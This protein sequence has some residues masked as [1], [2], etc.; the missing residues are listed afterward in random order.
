MTNNDTIRSV[1]FALD[2]S[3]AEIGDLFFLGGSPI[4]DEQLMQYLRKEEDKGFEECPSEL[5]H[6]F[7]DGLI[8]NKRGA[9]DGPALRYDASRISNN[10]ILRKLRIAF[11]LKDTDVVDI[12][13]K[14]DFRLS[15]SELGAMSRKPSHQHYVKCGDQVIRYFLRGLVGSVR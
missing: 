14:V 5:L 2:L 8:I 4:S 10:M 3:D 12:L 11:S 6:A 9:K 15:K 13:K 1:R 7:L